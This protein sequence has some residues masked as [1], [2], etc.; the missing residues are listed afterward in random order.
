[1]DAKHPIL[2]RFPAVENLEDWSRDQNVGVWSGE[3][4]I[5]LSPTTLKDSSEEGVIRVVFTTFNEFDEILVPDQK[6]DGP[7]R[8]LNSKVISASLGKAKHAPL[9]DPVRISFKHLRTVNVSNPVCVFWNYTTRFWSEDGCKLIASN[10]THSQCECEHLTNFA[11]IMDEGSNGVAFAKTAVTDQITI[12]IASVA[13]LVCVTI[14]LFSIVIT[15]RRFKVTYQCRAVL[16]KSGIPCFHKTKELSEKDKKQGNFY[17]VTPKLNGLNTDGSVLGGQNIEMDTEQYFQHMLAMQ[18]SQDSLG[19]A[20]KSVRRNTISAADI[21]RETNNG[22]HQETALNEQQDQVHTQ[23]PLTLNFRKTLKMKNNCGHAT[24]G[25]ASGI[26][27]ADIAMQRKMINNTR[28]MSPF[29]HIYMEIDPK[30]DTDHPAAPQGAVYETMNQSETYMLSSVSDMSEEDFRRAS[31]DVSRQ[32]SNR[33]AENKPLL[34]QGLERSM[35]G[36]AAGIQSQSM[37]LPAHL[38]NNRNSLLPSIAGLRFQDQK[39][40][41]GQNLNLVSSH[42]EPIPFALSNGEIIHGLNQNGEPIHT[43]NLTEEQIKALNLDSFPI[44]T[45]DNGL[46]GHPGM[47]EA[48]AGQEA[49]LQVTTVNGNQFVCLNLQDDAGNE[50]NF[51]NSLSMILLPIQINYKL[52]KILVKIFFLLALTNVMFCSRKQHINVCS[53]L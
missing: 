32:S 24:I 41:Q 10:L 15:W 49:P 34:R 48:R 46:M 30:T 2:Q 13:T 14:L 28:A 52:M 7:L 18:K 21:L 31:S 26:Q 6:P 29:N 3:D 35:F 39:Q 47:I 45:N 17:T 1:M 37:R 11:L 12:I 44:L 8:F 9:L 38:N 25:P 4:S 42:I 51:H 43:L 5:Q 19:Q 23:Q 27:A 22:N 53:S 20:H 36:N 33:Y 40:Q 16:Q 50:K